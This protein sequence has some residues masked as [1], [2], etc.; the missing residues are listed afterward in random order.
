MRKHARGEPWLVQRVKLNQS[1]NAKDKGVDA[2]FGF[3]YMGSAEFEFGALFKALK[4]MRENADAYGEPVRLKDENGRVIWFVGPED[5]LAFA[6]EFFADQSYDK[7]EIRLKECS[8]MVDAYQPERPEYGERAPIGWWAIDQE[9]PWLLFVK[10]DDAREWLSRLG[11][12]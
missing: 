6:T 1:P 9:I 12:K 11:G 2:Y 3:D 4:V 8:R 5:K 7:R 10:K